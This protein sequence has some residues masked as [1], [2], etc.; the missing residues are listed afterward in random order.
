[1][2]FPRSDTPRSP[3]PKTPQSSSYVQE[4]VQESDEF[5]ALFPHRYDYIYA[6]HPHPDQAPQWFTESR[7]PLSDRLIQ[8]GAYLY[9]V[10]F[11]SETDYLLADIDIQSFY[12]PTHDPFA[13]AR[14][15]AALEPLGLVTAV[16]CTSS[17]SGGLHL[18]FP[19]APACQSWKIAAAARVLL[20]QAGFKLKPGQLELFPDPKPFTPG[21]APAL[22]NAHRLPLQAGSYLVNE[23]Y[24]PVWSDRPQFVRQWH[25]AQS[26]N[27]LNQELLEQVLKQSRQRQ[28]KLSQR[29][30]KFLNDLN[31]EIEAGWTDFGQTNRLLGRITMRCY[32][33][34]HILEGGSPLTGQALVE[35][36][37]MTAKSLP[38]YREY[39]R[40]QHEIE[41]RATEW[42]R[43]IENSHYYAYGLQKGMKASLQPDPV[44]SELPKLSWNE[45]RSQDT[46]YKIR[47]AIAQML[48]TN[49]L[50]STITARFNALLNYGIGGSS[51]YKHRDL[52]H[53]KY[54]AKINPAQKETEEKK[55]F[56]NSTSLFGRNDSNSSIHK[57]SGDHT[58][59]ESVP[60]SI[61]VSNFS[62]MD[63]QV[64]PTADRFEQQFAAQAEKMQQYLDSGDPILMAEAQAWIAVHPNRVQVSPDQPISSTSMPVSS[65]RSDLLATIDVQVK[66]L[67]WNRR[68]VRDDLLEQFGTPHRYQLSEPELHGRVRE[69]GSPVISIRGGNATSPLAGETN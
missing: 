4:Y 25:F 52:W 34:H 42:A 7:H 27:E 41:Q 57:G 65:D 43:C 64:A 32:I 66:R 33:F 47:Q 8:Q 46:R 11:N 39:C 48:E 17:Y 50:P 29:A 28:R 49:T 35:A 61:E 31:A 40:H 23:D 24:Q 13:I 59:F 68:R 22:F 63:Q 60:E 10:R 21:Q 67:G 62:V 15:Q 3:T 9:G 58:T 12:H 53:P 18:Y 45:Q 30:D 56:Q 44:D 26:C 16:V 5:L 54:L 51:L 2:Y 20:E 19:F 6:S 38:G 36:I 1:M 55:Y 14:L 37:V 69:R